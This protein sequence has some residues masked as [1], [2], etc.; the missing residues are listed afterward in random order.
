MAQTKAPEASATS[1]TAFNIVDVLGAMQRI[2]T[3]LHGYLAA[4]PQYV[5]PRGIMAC[6]E[7]M[8][9]LTSVLPMPSNTGADTVDGSKPKAG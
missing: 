3:D 7:R 5:D 6:L 4:P 2:C 1:P 9:E 8:A